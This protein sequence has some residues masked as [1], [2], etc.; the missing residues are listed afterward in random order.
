MTKPELDSLTT[1]RL[2]LRALSGVLRHAQDGELPLSAWT[3]NMPQNT[4]IAMIRTCFP[5]SGPLHP[6]PEHQYEAIR[7]TLPG[8]FI[9]VYELLVRRA[10]HHLP[11]DHVDWMARAVAAACLGER[12]LW[13]DLGLQD[14]ASVSLLLEHY[15]PALY[16]RNSRQLRW[17]RFILDEMA[18]TS[19]HSVTAPPCRNCPDFA[20][21]FPD[22][23]ITGN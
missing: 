7:Q 23:K 18:A 21:C 16:Q 2:M 12:H 13:Q 6:L 19:G 15:F 20:L 10:P 4:L 5:E 11:S 22:R 3:L 1:G 17:K 9:P 14:R 8:G